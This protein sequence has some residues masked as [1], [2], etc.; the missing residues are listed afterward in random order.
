M[1]DGATRRAACRLLGGG[2][3]LVLL[4]PAAEAAAAGEALATRFQFDAGGTITLMT[5]KVDMGQGSRTELTMVAAEE[6]F[7]SPARIRVVMGDTGL[8][9]DDGGTFAS[10]TTPLTVPVVRRA[11]AAARAFLIRLAAERWD[12][13]ASSLR[14]EDGR[15]LAAER[16]VGYGQLARAGRMGEPVPE[17]AGTVAPAEWRIC[18]KPLAPVYGLEIVTGR[19]KYSA[20]AS[21][22]GMLHGRAVRAPYYIARLEGYD[23]APAERLGAKV[24]RDGEFLGVVAEDEATAGKAAR[25]VQAKWSGEPLP[26][27]EDLYRRFKE[28]SRPPVPGPPGSRYPGLFQQGDLAR[29]FA[30]ATVRHETRHRIPP[31]AHVPL[32]PRA[33]LAEWRGEELTVWHG[34]QVPFGVRQELAQ[35]FGIPPERVRVVPCQIGGA[36][37]SKHRGEVALEAARLARAAGRPVKVVWS[38]EDEFNQ[39][40]LRPAGVIEVRSGIDAAGKIVAWDF[41]NYAS[42]PAG[43]AVPYAIPNH[44]CGFHRAASPL[45]QGSYR[46]LAAVANTFAREEHVDELASL[47]GRDPLEF[48]LANIENPRLREAVER[49]AERFGWGRAK[50]G[51]GRGFGM[52]VN[53]EKGG[54]QAL[55]A[56]LAVEGGKVKL[57]RMVTAFDC[58]AIINPDNLRNQIEGAMIMG[59]GGALFEQ[60]RFDNQR[61]LNTRLSRYRVPRF[62]D[63]PAIETILI[64]RRDL[65]STGAG[66]PP[67]TPVAP[68]IAA[69]IFSATGKRLRDLPLEPGLATP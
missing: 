52:A 66:E 7:V 37:G 42:G 31:I 38:R 27:I 15:V 8:V 18:G 40:P 54:H 20:D 51:A 55:F 19:L 63:I 57:E 17:N 26:S 43:L 44:F 23:A 24:I 10:L 46:S 50:S 9:P 47:A 35:A 48:R 56:A 12:L 62:P 25:A 59:I 41:H 2:T 32:E 1:A 34:T 58:G 61:L 21:R 36:F 13:P 4:E 11:S 16:A 5:G 64:D 53:V 3:L 49:A 39:G 45:R 68:A 60:V 30:R 69:A 29:G 67:I 65:P 6:L 22:P 14:V 28:D 33:A